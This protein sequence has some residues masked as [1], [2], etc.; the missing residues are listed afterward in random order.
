MF[1]WDFSNHNTYLFT[2]AQS[3]TLQCFK[4]LKLSIT[5]NGAQKPT[6]PTNVFDI[7]D[8]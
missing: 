2:P 1:N 5:L 8:K 3:R 7:K 4:A 6:F